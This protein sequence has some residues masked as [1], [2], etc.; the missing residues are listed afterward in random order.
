VSAATATGAFSSSSLP[1]GG[2]AP[3]FDS[4]GVQAMLAQLQSRPNDAPLLIQIGNAY[5][6]GQRYQ[7]AIEHN[8]RALNIR[9]DDVNVRT[10]MGTAMWYSGDADGALKQFEQSLTYQ[11]THAQTMF[12]IGI[13]KWQ[14][15]HDNKGA[16]Q[17]WER[18]LATNPDYVDRQKVLDLMQ[19]VKS[20]A[21]A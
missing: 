1:T 15:K 5:Y 2:A 18:L 13:V 6:D 7:E 12:N 9:A 14:G 21:G 8:G 17:V 11:P 16:L 3:A 19:K 4:A 20:G 10:D